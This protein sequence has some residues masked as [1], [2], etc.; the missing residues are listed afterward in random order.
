MQKN[1]RKI[2]SSIFE[3]ISELKS[4]KLLVGTVIRIKESDIFDK[5]YNDLSLSL[6][7][8]ELVYKNELIPSSNVWTYSK[9]NIKWYFKIFKDQE[10]EKRTV[11]MWER[12][13]FW[14]WSKWSFSL[15]RTFESF[16][17]INYWPKELSFKIDLLKEENINWERFFIFKIIIKDIL[18]INEKDF[19]EK[20]L[21][22]INLLQENFYPIN[23]FDI[24]TNN[25]EYLDTLIIDWEIFK[26]WN[27]DDDLKKIIWSGKKLSKINIEYISNRYDFIK[28]LNPKSLIIWASWMRRYFWAQFSDDLVIFENRDYGNAI[29]I[30]FENW[31]DLSKLSRLEIQN[32]PL[33]E[34]IR[35]PHKW[36]WEEKVRK[37]IKS[38]LKKNNE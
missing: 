23:I 9:K 37:I 6:I 21:F 32:R 38:R 8:W 1:F 14:D 28:S 25:D 18:N 20:L 16:P 10:K 22:N 4:E 34:F 7:N 30:L 31:K 17:R 19:E 3:K 36:N 12:P 35:I 5:Q 13:Y 2:P 29:Y 11:Y 33:D 15:Y 27:R 26:L 24:D